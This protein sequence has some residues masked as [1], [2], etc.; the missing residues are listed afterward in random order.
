[1]HASD[2]W[3]KLNGRTDKS[4]ATSF[5]SH[6]GHPPATHP[7]TLP[8]LARFSPGIS[9]LVQKLSKLVG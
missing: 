2:P 9:G 5:K 1:M 7:P 3:L 8:D 6:K 4:I